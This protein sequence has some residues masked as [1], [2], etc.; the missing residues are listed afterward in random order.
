MVYTAKMQVIF[1]EIKFYYPTILRHYTLSNTTNILKI[2][3]NIL[4]NRLLTTIL[5]Q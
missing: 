2:N 3:I 4:I 1:K 5:M